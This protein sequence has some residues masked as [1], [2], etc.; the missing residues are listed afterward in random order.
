[1]RGIKNFYFYPAENIFS[2]KTVIMRQHLTLLFSLLLHFAYGQNATLQGVVTDIATGEPLIGVTVKSA[3]TG[4]AT[5]ASGA[6]SLSLPAGNHEIVFSFIGYESRTQTLR[7]TAGQTLQLGD[8]DN[9]LQT[10]TVT[11]GK[12]EKP[13]GEVTVSIDVLKPRLL[14][15]TNTTSIDEVLVKVPGVSIIDGQASI[16]G[17]AGFSYGAGTRVLLLVDDIPALQA[18]AGFPNWD[19]FPVEN[20]SQIEVLKG[21]AS[22]LYGSSAM[23][24]IINIRTG[25]AKDKPETNAAVFAK[26]WDTPKDSRKKWWGA[27]TSSIQLPV[28]TGFSVG[29]R[30]KI[31]KLDLVLGMYGLYRDSYNKNT[32]SRYGR[33][34]PNLRYRFSDRLTFGLNTNINFG[35]SGSF[36]IWGN[37]S[38]AALQPGLGSA[39]RSLGRLRYTIDPSVQYF[40]QGG[41]RHKFLGRYFYVHNNN[42]GNQSN[43][44]RMYYGEYQI[45]RRMDHLGLVATAG[46]VGILTTVEAEL[47]NGNFKTRN[48]AGYLQL[49]Y[50]VFNRLNLSGGVRYEQNRLN[51]PEVIRIDATNLD[52]LPNGGEFK[53]SKPVY[54]LGANYQI[55]QASYLRASWGQGYRYPTIA[56]KFIN[57]DFSAGNSVRP[58]PKLVSETGWTA[59]MGLKQGFRVGKWQGFVDITGF[60]SEYQNMMEFV[61]AEIRLFPTVGASFESQ[62]SGD[63]RITG[64]E[65]SVV[66]QGQIGN[67]TLAIITGYTGINP[68][69]KEFNDSLRLVYGSSDTS[70][71]L[72]YRYNHMFK[73]DAEYSI[74]RFS[75]GSAVQ[76]NSFM[77]AIDQIFELPFVEPFAG[78]RNFRMNNNGGFTVVDLRA[79]YK[80]N[81]TL[82]VS[83][84]C[85]N[86]FNEEYSA[87]PALLEAPRNYTLRLDWRI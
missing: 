11:A 8:S 54:R 87:R 57:T 45:Q 5:D 82:K 63:T 41:N 36:F 38:I 18:D 75:L 68:K 83:A 29:H 22:A 72:K 21:A 32:Y 66:G 79:S 84:L 42:S 40:D 77:K 67:G 60:V 27:D 56:E 43:D 3:E 51:G 13:L 47:Y 59:E 28:E 15:N 69:Y 26:I 65:I 52:T 7:L 14:D 44:S 85:S 76:Y 10:A 50:K 58:N 71:V 39:S 80:L 33:I 4:S 78:V 74:G 16:R 48:I 53:E 6:Y 46:V 9:L 1:M 24:G 55:A 61:L 34:T 73:F 81:S 64:A 62:N 25:F 20:I 86:L 37:D 70:N 49:D 30:E 2:S 17:G 12:F 19:D 31:G 35:K 23:N